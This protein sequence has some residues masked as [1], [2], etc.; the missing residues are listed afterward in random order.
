MFS[1]DQII[2]QY[3]AHL[4]LYKKAILREYLQ[5]QILAIIFKT[6]F[7]SKIAFLGGTALRIIHDN[8][9][10]SEDLD[11]DNLSL[12]KEDLLTLGDLIKSEMKS[13]GFLVDITIKTTGTYRLKIRLPQLLYDLNL[14]PLS[15][16]RILIYVDMLPQNFVFK[17]QNF[18]LDKFGLKVHIKSVPASILLSQ[19]IYTAFNRRRIMGRDFFDI[20]FLYELAVKPDMLYLEKKLGIQNHN[21]L[22]QYILDKSQELNFKNLVADVQPFLFNPKDSQKI[23][24]FKDFVEKKPLTGVYQD[25]QVAL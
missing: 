17:P 14:S 13:M 12:T 19:K 21:S 4:H 25:V 18:L 9:R 7:G 23:I 11:F 15:Q 16:E 8:Q 6:S 2:D 20:V 5:H 1:L 24:G 3:P 22:K 10:F